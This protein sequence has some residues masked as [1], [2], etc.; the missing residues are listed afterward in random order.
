MTA[1][2]TIITIFKTRKVGGNRISQN[3]PNNV[4]AMAAL[5]VPEEARLGHHGCCCLGDRKMA[6]SSAAA[7]LWPQ[8]STPQ[9]HLSSPKVLYETTLRCSGLVTGSRKFLQDPGKRKQSKSIFRNTPFAAQ[10][11]VVFHLVPSKGIGCCES[12]K[13]HESTSRPVSPHPT[14]SP[15]PVRP[16][17]ARK[18]SRDETAAEG[19]DEPASQSGAAPTTGIMVPL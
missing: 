14:T 3:R 18:I 15:F 17:F 10:S 7:S 9:T 8:P 6:L 13:K 16:V 5:V 11:R 12:Q 2:A 19:L 1:S 4:R